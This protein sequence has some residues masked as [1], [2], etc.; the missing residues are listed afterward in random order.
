M[1]G[2]LKE[3]ENKI[4]ES[5]EAGEVIDLDLT[6][7]TI[8]KFTPEISALIERQKNLEVLILSN[9]GLKSLENFPKCKLQALDLSHNK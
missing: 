8:E 4:K 3:I 5:Q 1:S 7:V 6:E 9:C 2:A